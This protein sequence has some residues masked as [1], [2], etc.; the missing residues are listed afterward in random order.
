MAPR[1]KGARRSVSEED[2]DPLQLDNVMVNQIANRVFE[3]L[4]EAGLGH[5]APESRPTKRQSQNEDRCS[6]IPNSHPV[7]TLHNGLTMDMTQ[8]MTTYDGTD[9]VLKAKEWLRD[10]RAL[11]RIYDWPDVTALEVARKSLTASA[12][13]WYR[14]KRE[15]FASVHDFEKLFRQV[16]VAEGDKTARIARMTQRRQKNGETAVEYA[17]DKLQMCEGID[18]PINELKDRVFEGL[19]SRNLAQ[20]LMADAISDVD[21]LLAAIR[22]R[23]TMWKFSGYESQKPER[24]TADRK[25]SF[26]DAGTKKD[27]PS[28]RD[29][30]ERETTKSSS[31]NTQGTNQNPPSSATTSRT[32]CFN[33]WRRGHSESQCTNEKRPIK[34]TRC[35]ELGHGKSRCTNVEQNS[36]SM[37][38]P[39]SSSNVN[40]VSSN[41][42]MPG[43]GDPGFRLAKINGETVTAMLDDGSSHCLIKEP[44]A[45]RLFGAEIKPSNKVFTGFTMS[46]QDVKASGYVVKNVEIDGVT[47]E[48]AIYILTELSF[49]TDL[50]IGRS[51]LFDPTVSYAKIYDRICIRDVSQGYDPKVLSFYNYSFPN[52]ECG[53]VNFITTDNVLSKSNYVNF[54][55]CEVRSSKTNEPLS[56]SVTVPTFTSADSEI[57][58]NVCIARVPEP[59]QIE[60]E[61]SMLLELWQPLAYE[62]FR[63]G[64][65]VPEEER[66]E[67]V[68]TINRDF[69]R[70]FAEN[71]FELGMT[72]V[73]QMTIDEE[74]GSRPPARKPYR[75][76][77]ENEME[78]DRLIQEWKSAGIVTESNSEYA[79]P[80][81]LANKKDGQKRPVFDFRLLNAQTKSIPYP[82]PSIDDHLTS[83]SGALWFAVLDLS[84]GYL[85][86]LV[87]EKDQPKTAFVTPSFKGQFVRMPFGL[88][89]A[90]AVFQSLMNKV[91]GYSR[92]TFAFAYLDDILIYACTIDELKTRIYSVLLALQQAG[93]TCKLTKCLF[94]TETV[95][96]LG[97]EISIGQLRPG[98][99]K[100]AAIREFPVPKDAHEVRRWLGLT[101][102][103]R[104]FVKNYAQIASPLTELTRKSVPF[105]W[106]EV[107]QRAFETLKHS[108]I[109]EPTL[110]LYDPKLETELHTDASSKGLAGLLLQKGNDGNLRLVSCFSQ[111]TTAAESMYHS[112]RLELM[113]IVRSVEKFRNY[114]IGIPFAVVTDCQALTFLN[115]NKSLNPQTARWAVL[116]QDY[117]ITYRYR[118]GD[119]MRHADAL[120]RAPIENSENDKGGS[121][122]EQIFYV[123]SEA[124]RIAT[125]QQEDE[126]IKEIVSLLRRYDETKQLPDPSFISF[127]EFR[128]YLLENGVLYRDNEN[129][130]KR[131]V[132]P[133]SQRKA[134]CIK[135]HELQGHYAA[136]KVC[137]KIREKYYFPNMRNYIKNHVARC[138][139]C[140]AQKYPSGKEVGKSQLSE[141]GS[142]P[143]IK[144]HID[145][146]GPFVESTKRNSHVLV[147]KDS[148]SRYVIL[149]AVP[150]TGVHFTKQKLSL[151]FE[152][153]GLPRSIV[154]DRGSAFTS[155]EFADFCKARN[156]HHTLISVRRPNSNGL[157][158]RANKIITPQITMYCERSDQRDWDKLLPEIQRNVNSSVNRS[159]GKT[160]FEL[161]LGYQPNFDPS[162]LTAFVHGEEIQQPHEEMWKTAKEKILLSQIVN[163]EYV[164]KKRLHAPE[165]DIG[166]IVYVKFPQ[167]TKLHAKYRG[168]MTIVRKIVNDVYEVES[169]TLNE[170]GEVYRSQVHV[171]HLRKFPKLTEDSDDDG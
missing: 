61:P 22:R 118:P 63:F 145:H 117:E 65:H 156:I 114:L 7:P 81:L 31:S 103:F 98:K 166:Q 82:M 129:G 45:M 153:F 99:A 69:R 124:D 113:A 146:I 21:E 144:L 66:R 20:N 32:L 138:I 78:L 75:S 36:A 161:V 123:V 108:I 152:A 50:L 162:V 35:G 74:P 128:K 135:Y 19:H 165:Y 4:Q 149:H 51:W 131:F 27:Q 42:S 39:N 29:A 159:T 116:L 136:D 34:C 164:D 167:T 150:N 18:I 1:K 96:Y 59:V 2:I 70:A 11:Q 122:S 171:A 126:R 100:T 155:Y 151:F 147:I 33:C 77:R 109:S 68:N 89:N 10:W 88:R 93:L 83:L 119:R 3:K 157:V 44:I 62:K 49:P 168:P 67:F 16:F 48:V 37:A 170:R 57:K 14:L 79:A 141:P 73:V 26:R 76:S 43:G 105:V 142:R 132:L 40:L 104:R 28:N 52:E 91:L 12:A 133:K 72:D 80:A 115:K 55:Q 71:V 110:A 54:V 87:R 148:L 94:F 111:K 5:V 106:K 163:K 25:P 47:V 127:D 84:Q 60:M 160:P 85:Q 23:E 95:E 143:F 30:T 38:A 101:G 112:S 8:N 90:P 140:I 169:I 46:V 92:K 53:K 41:Q 17:I 107:Q 9:D 137:A 121:E 154:S 158:E 120:S 6:C 64:T 102:F 130:Q 15:K 56:K 13:K 97:Y 125:F 134:L 139:D 86:V 24:P 58:K